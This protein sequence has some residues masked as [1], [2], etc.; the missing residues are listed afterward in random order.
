MSTRPYKLIRAKRRTLSLQI[1]PDMTLVVKAPQYVSER[2]I[3]K[4]LTD[5]EDW[6]SKRLKR[7][8]KAPPAKPK[9]YAHGEKFLYLGQPHTLTY[10]DVTQIAAVAGI[11][12]I[13]HASKIRARKEITRWYMAQAKEIISGLVANHAMEMGTSYGMIRYSDTSSKWGSCAPD[14]DLQFNWRLIM[15]PMLIVRY[16]VIHELAHTIEKNHSR[17]FWKIVERHNPS[18]RQ[19]R[20]WLK[21]HGHTLTL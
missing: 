19:Q 14:N 4:F 21:T 7:L 6:I 8:Q 17:S 2:D 11:L 1:L 18:Y 16:V 3:N 12:H 5:H 20:K 10:A 13:P 15:A 9:S